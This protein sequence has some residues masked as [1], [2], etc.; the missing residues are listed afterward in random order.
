LRC[1]FEVDELVA[2]YYVHPISR[3]QQDTGRRI[4]ALAT[5]FAP[6]LITIIGLGFAMLVSLV[7]QLV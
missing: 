6:M 1:R 4:R 3:L 2:W 5:A 7:T